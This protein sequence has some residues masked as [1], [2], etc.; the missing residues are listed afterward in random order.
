[1]LTSAT[2]LLTTFGPDDGHVSEPETGLVLASTDVVAH[3]MVSLAWLIEN[4]AKLVIKHAN[5]YSSA[6]VFIGEDTTDEDWDRVISTNLTKEQDAQLRAAFADEARVGLLVCMDTHLTETAQLAD[7]F[8]FDVGLIPE[9]DVFNPVE[10]ATAPFI[11][12]GQSFGA[13]RRRNDRAMH[14]H[15]LVDL[16][17]GSA[18]NP[19]TKRKK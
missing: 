7:E 1:M 2:K 4:R 15:R 6:A 9:I 18:A 17:A 13:D 8:T 10:T 14:G 11:L 5:A 16:D 12:P 19:P 3:D